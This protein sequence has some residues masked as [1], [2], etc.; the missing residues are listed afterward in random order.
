MTDIADRA[1][2]QEQCQR[3]FA[4]AK[5]QQKTTACSQPFCEDCGEIIPAKRQQMIVGCTRCVDC[6]QRHELKLKNYRK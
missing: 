6:Q 4:L 5:M 2:E 3:E 1:S